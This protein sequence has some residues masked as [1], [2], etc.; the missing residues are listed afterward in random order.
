MNY[1]KHNPI[2]SGLFVEVYPMIRLNDKSQIIEQFGAIDSHIS[3]YDTLSTR[4]NNP[5]GMPHYYDI[6]I[7]LDN[8]EFFYELEN[9]K[10]E[11]LDSAINAVLKRFKLSDYDLIEC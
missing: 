3:G 11:R 4:D 10:P 9:V 8:G 6:A 2:P 7:R 1:N 5:D